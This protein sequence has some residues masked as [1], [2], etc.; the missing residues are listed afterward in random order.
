MIERSKW[1]L[2]EPNGIW[3]IA[4]WK[5]SGKKSH[6]AFRKLGQIA[7]MGFSRRRGIIL[8]TASSEWFERDERGIIDYNYSKEKGAG[9]LSQSKTWGA[10]GAGTEKKDGPVPPR[11]FALRPFSIL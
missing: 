5:N 2:R 11:P 6:S 7:V 9:S 1:R 3:R 4:L 10:D 8:W